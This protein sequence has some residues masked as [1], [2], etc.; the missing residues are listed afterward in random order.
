VAL[1]QDEPSETTEEV[2]TDE[3]PSTD[4][5]AEDGVPA[6]RPPAPPVEMTPERKAKAEY[7][8]KRRIDEAKVWNDGVRSA[9]EE[10]VATSGIDVDTAQN[11]MAALNKMLETHNM[12][13]AQ[14]QGGELK[15]KDGRVRLSS[16]REATAEAV[17]AILGTEKME[18]LR[19]HLRSVGG[20]Y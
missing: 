8:E 17:K 3:T 15:A 13:R 12:I 14:M 4:E 5:A 9:T 6:K 7:W 20:S 11:L 19:D 2:Q 10:W 1:G 18:A 16:N